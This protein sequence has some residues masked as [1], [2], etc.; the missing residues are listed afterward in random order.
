MTGSIEVQLL[1]DRL[2]HTFRQFAANRVDLGRGASW[3]TSLIF[4]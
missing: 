2:F 4:T 1:D 3:P